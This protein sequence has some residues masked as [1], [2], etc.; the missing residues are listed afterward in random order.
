MPGTPAAGGAGRRPQL[1]DKEAGEGR[2]W[3]SPY[4]FDKRMHRP[5][6]T[7]AGECRGSLFP[8]NPTQSRV[9][10]GSDNPGSLFFLNL[11]PVRKI[12]LAVYLKFI[13]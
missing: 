7:G 11:S 13:K 3:Q 5:S 4:H 8:A 1:K 6:R 12:P 2:V 10:N 9:S